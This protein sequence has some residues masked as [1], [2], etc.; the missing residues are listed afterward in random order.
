MAPRAPAPG[1]REVPPSSVPLEDYRHADPD[2]II[3]RQFLL[4]DWAQQALRNEFKRAMQSSGVRI[5]SGDISKLSDL[6]NAI[7]RACDA[8]KKHN[9]LS[10]ELQKRLSPQ[11]FLEAALRK[12]EGQDAATIRYAIKRLK[13]YLEKIGPVSFQDRQQM[14]DA[15]N[16]LT[17][18][19]SNAAQAVASLEDE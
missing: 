7:V 8:L 4:L 17:G 1:P 13:A 12:V 10:D 16:N 9:D 19:N 18:K 3:S 15:P 11:A 2:A 14:G 5:D 6:S